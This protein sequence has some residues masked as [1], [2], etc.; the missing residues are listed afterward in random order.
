MPIPQNDYPL[1][2]G[3]NVN[4][5]S[6]NI[7]YI[8]WFNEFPAGHYLHNHINIVFNTLGANLKSKSNVVDINIDNLNITDLDI[9]NQV[10]TNLL[11][12]IQQSLP[13]TTVINKINFKNFK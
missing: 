9:L 13:A 1:I 11:A 10:K 5:Y 6:V 4:N 3:I 8:N 2:R 12:G 7:N